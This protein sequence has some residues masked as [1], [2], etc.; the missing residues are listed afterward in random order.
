MVRWGKFLRIIQ[1]DQY[2]S[3]QC[4][5]SKLLCTA[6]KPE[7]NI[8]LSSCSHALFHQSIKLRTIKKHVFSGMRGW[9][10]SPCAVKCVSFSHWELFPVMFSL[11]PLE[12]LILT[13]MF[14]LVYTSLVTFHHVSA[15][16]GVV[17]ACPFLTFFLF[18][19]ITSLQLKS[20]LV[21]S[22]LPLCAQSQGKSC[23]FIPTPLILVDIALCWNTPGKRNDLPF[24][25][26]K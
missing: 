16:R 2:F 24:L 23:S 13:F 25:I 15:V 17:K 18:I 5:W 9:G 12:R 20:G 6:G 4:I 8:L 11:Q 10:R 26:W 7:K 14:I 21:S 19:Q 1:S 3:K 22:L